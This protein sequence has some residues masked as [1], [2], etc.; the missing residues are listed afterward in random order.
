MT[1]D[2]DALLEEAAA[3]S[4]IHISESRA[5]RARLEPVL[6]YILNVVRDQGERPLA[7][8]RWA[9]ADDKLASDTWTAV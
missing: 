1:L 8:N 9:F 5:H 2:Y 6:P 3:L 4:A 7:F